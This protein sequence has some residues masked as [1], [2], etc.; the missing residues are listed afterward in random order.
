[1]VDTKRLI[2]ALRLSRLSC[3]IKKPCFDC[4]LMEDCLY[5]QQNGAKEAADTIEHLETEN[6][7]LRE[8]VSVVEEATAKRAPLTIMRGAT[9]I[10]K[11]SYS[12]EEENAALR[13]QLDDAKRQLRQR[14]AMNTEQA[15]CIDRLI[16]ERD[17]ALNDLRGKCSVCVHYTSNHREGVCAHCCREYMSD[18]IACSDLWQWRG[19]QKEDGRND[20]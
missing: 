4:E 12:L 11:G 3:G 10:I 14:D 2:K 1:M 18:V 5:Y 17:A 7:T 20:E 15:K 19:P 16:A 8:E 6:A 13:E 9:T